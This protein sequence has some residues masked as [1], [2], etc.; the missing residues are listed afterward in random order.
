MIANV[1]PLKQLQLYSMTAGVEEQASLTFELFP[2]LA[3]DTQCRSIRAGLALEPERARAGNMSTSG[4]DYTCEMV[5]GGGLKGIQMV[6]R[7]C[8][9]RE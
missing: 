6:G 2:V 5:L 7:P 8:R 1:S 4:T 9:Q 3:P